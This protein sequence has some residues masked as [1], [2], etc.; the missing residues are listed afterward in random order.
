MRRRRR[1]K[2]TEELEDWEKEFGKNRFRFKDLYY[3]TNAFEE[4]NLLGAGGFGRVYRAPEHTRTGRAT[5]ASNVFAFG[6]FLL[7]GV[8]GRRPVEIQNDNN[9]TFVLVDWVFALWNKGNILDAI[10]PNMGSE[11]N[12][13]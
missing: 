13:E 1:R 2:F 4:T 8:C 5:T 3:A 12:Q 9:E 7:E 6:A 10:Y 11:L